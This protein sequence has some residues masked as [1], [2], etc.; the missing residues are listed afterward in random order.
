MSFAL[1]A[2]L[3]ACSG[4]DEKKP[5]TNPEACVPPEGGE[6]FEAGSAEGHPDPLGAKEAGQAR[7]GRIKDAANFPQPAHGRQG[8]TN[9]D[10]VLINDKIS[11]VIEDLGL[12]DGYS[13][14][15]GEIIAVDRVGDDGK[16]L[17]LSYYQETLAGIGTESI[18]PDSLTII[19]DGSN[20]EAAVVR[21]SGVLAPIPFIADSLG[22]IFASYGLRATHDFVLEPGAEYV[23][24]RMSVI[25]DRNQPID[26]GVERD[27][28]DEL[29]GFFHGS[30]AQTVTPEFGYGDPTSSVSWVGFDSGKSSFAW[31]APRGPMDFALTQSGFALFLGP[32]FIAEACAVTTVEHADIIA[33]G[34][35]YDGLRE[36]VRRVD[37]EEAWREVRGR[38]TN[39]AGD[40]VAGA[41]VHAEN[42]AGE[43]LSR[44]TTADDGTF[45][46]HAPPGDDVVL[47]PQSQGYPMHEGM[48][49]PPGESEA[50]LAFAANGTLHVVA[51]DDSG[52]VRLPVRIQVVPTEP[53]AAWPSAY[54]VKDEVN[55]RLYQEFAV[56]GEA[57]L[58]V[59]PGEHQVIVTRGFEYEQV[60]SAINVDAG[61]MVEV[62]ATLEQ[63]VDTTN[64]FC[65]DFHIHSWYSADSSD[66]I[67]YKLKGA[68]ADGLDIPVS[69]EH[70][71][72]ADFQPIIE[73]MELEAWA[74]GI[75]AEELTTFKFGHFGV[76][77][78]QPKPGMLNN[79]AV[80]W[81]GMTPGGL[82]DAA[83]SQPESPMVIVNHPSDSSIMG[84]FR[85]AGY[86]R[87]TGRGLDDTWSDHFDA[88]E[89]FNDSD[90]EGSR[91]NSVGD[92]F[93]LLNAGYRFWATGASDSHHLRTSAVGYPRTCLTF[94]HDDIGMLTATSVQEAMAK[95]AATI[96]GGLFMTVEGPG[97]VGPGGTVTTAAN[98]SAT[99][100]VT[101][102]APSWVD[103]RTLETIVNGVSVSV[104]DLMPIGPGPGK[105]FMVQV[106]VERDAARDVNWVVFHAKGE[107]DLAPMLPGKRPFAVSNPIFLE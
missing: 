58:V 92:W 84:Y 29:V 33:G 48:T 62:P 11:V 86:D 24:V 7:A 78:L 89:V 46:I 12:S 95:G 65:A 80:D 88:I 8:I 100:T 72:V 28:S 57:T 25:N 3:P 59:P 104:E 106:P 36:A 69:S 81:I 38:V 102:Q 9:G 76:F 44:T 10:I 27:G 37:G 87:E 20:G 2:V 105:R 40:G 103:A 66:P 101:V 73:R 6:V 13:R 45:S 97:G 39:A 1:L 93:S 5:P 54:G 90:F 60:T 35:G 68:V 26:F 55:G 14:F 77:P 21:A 49:V 56:T 107:G 16:P 22:A 71:W 15:G 32:A 52:Q 17:G 51:T 47:V 31:R 70:E 82:F 50:D 61:D 53:I 99:F 94:D 85:M 43:Y 30:Q 96:S 79:G 23:R 19:N 63:T 75:P 91:E 18:L 64:V 67:D 98:G 74:F 4:D 41:W 83:H 34:P 42:A